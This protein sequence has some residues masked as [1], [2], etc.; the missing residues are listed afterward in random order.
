MKSIAFQI[1]N[2]RN[3]NTDV[4]MDGVKEWAEEHG[5]EYMRF[6]DEDPSMVHYWRKVFKLSE[7]MNQNYEYIIWFDSDIFIYDFKKDPR[8][9][10]RPDLDFIAAHDPSDPDDDSWFNAG[11]FCVRNSPGGKALID[12]WKSLYDASKWTKDENGKWTT[13]D[14]WAG[15]NYEQGAFCEQILQ[16]DEFKNKI[17]IYPSTTFNEIFNWKNPQPECFSIHLMRGLAQKIGVSCLWFHRLEAILWVSLFFVTCV[18]FKRLVH[19]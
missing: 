5:I 17:K 2:R 14:R 18:A 3:E 13:D 4:L 15:P 10:M 11:V 1:E 6:E 16:K 9:F 19:K 8:D 7:L 12:K